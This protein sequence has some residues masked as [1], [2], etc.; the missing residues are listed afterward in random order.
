MPEG[1]SIEE[2]EATVADYFDMLKK[3]LRGF[4]FNKSA[5]RRALTGRVKRSNPAIEQKHMNVSAILRDMDHPWIDGYKPLPNYQNLLRD[6]VLRWIAADLELSALVKK[7][8]AAT[9]IDKGST[10]PLL[11]VV[12]PPEMLPKQSLMTARSLSKVVSR[13]Y[14]EQEAR[15]S[16]LGSAG[17]AMVLR[18]EK[19]RLLGLGLDRLVDKVEHVAI[20]V[21]DREGFDIRSF[22]EGGTE[23]FI[24]VKTTNFGSRTPFYVTANELRVS[25]ACSDRYH[26]YRVFDFRKAPR[27][28]QLRGALDD[29]FRLSPTVYRASR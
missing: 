16:A 8:V 21:G 22:G 4:P 12:P 25:K 17:E 13:N 26:L 7:L 15:N 6:I 1:W 3:E 28:F 19:E 5:H 24:E 2:A 11:T 20:T 9:P 14:L 18:F 10:D 23:R 27:Q 29:S